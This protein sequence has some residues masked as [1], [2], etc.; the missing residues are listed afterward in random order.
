MNRRY[1]FIKFRLIPY[2]LIF[3]WFF[4]EFILDQRPGIIGS[5]TDF[6]FLRRERPPICL[7]FYLDIKGFF[8]LNDRLYPQKHPHLC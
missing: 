3:V 7:C 6:V 4:F 8:K 2:K 5:L 1:R